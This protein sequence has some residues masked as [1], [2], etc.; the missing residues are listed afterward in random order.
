M[1]INILLLLDY[2]DGYWKT[3]DDWTTPRSLNIN[4][5]VKRFEHHGFSVTL[6]SYRRI[7][8][9]QKYEGYYVL[10]GSSEDLCGGTKSYMED[11]LV[12]L[13]KS[14]ATLI[15]SFEYF[16]AHHNKVMMEILRNTFPSNI[17]QSVQAKTYR[18][19]CD[20]DGEEIQYPVVLKSA[21]GAGGM[22]VFLIHDRQQ[23]MRRAKK[24]SRVPSEWI[25][26]LTFLKNV[27][28][29]LLGR[30]DTY[31]RY[32][33]KFILQPY[34]PNLTGDYKVLIFWDHY[35][36]LH[37]LSRE[38]DFRASGSGIFCESDSGE[39][40]EIL[41]FAKMCHEAIKTPQLSLD[42]AYDQQHTHLIEYQC[43]SFG[44]KAMSMSEYHFVN[45]NDS[46]E[47]VDGRVNAEEEYA[48]SIEQY[49]TSHRIA[50]T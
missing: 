45:K 32:N 16:R 14:G 30:T 46:F 38:K 7:D 18:A 8:F 41:R 6:S 44:F 28:R 34:I 15:P 19:L 11:V 43:L 25:L 29:K 24:V 47:R 1:S 20:L 48:Y 10:Y 21:S 33:T 23:L 39:L 40:M 2:D 27:K 13:M 12:F 9:S 49:I 42:I 37:R 17:R 26:F 36:I 22:G 4:A 31:N 3:Y 50:S 5:L 35:F